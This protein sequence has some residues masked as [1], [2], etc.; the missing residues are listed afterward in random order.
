[1]SF[2]R[3]P[4]LAVPSFLLI[5]MLTPMATAQSLWQSRNEDFAMMFV[6]TRAHSIGDILT[7]VI[8]ESTDVLKQDQ[9]AMDK[10]SDG[11]FNFNFA[12]A[13]SGG[14]SPSASVNMAGDSTRAFDGNSQYRV[15]Q[16]FSDRIA[17]SVVQVLPNGY[18]VVQ[19]TRRRLVSQEQRELTVSGVV[20][21]LDIMPD[22]SVRSQFVADLDIQYGGCGSDLHFSNQGW[23]ARALNRIWPF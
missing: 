8:S 5:A 2:N 13:S 7:L 1:M 20:R 6:D 9:R 23:A 17:V 21:P 11:G 22:N 3:L 16:E 10:S 4:L 18:L 19:G 15:A 14:G 12:G